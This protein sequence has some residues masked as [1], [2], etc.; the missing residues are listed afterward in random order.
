[1]ELAVLVLLTSRLM[2]DEIHRQLAERGYASLRPAHGF[3]FQLIASRGG[4]TGVELA[5]HLSVTRQAAGQMVDEL[6]RS[7]Y[8]TRQP[9]PTDARLRRVHLS[10]RGREVLELSARLWAAQERDWERL[11][12]E[13][14]IA[15]VQSGLAAFIQDRGGFD[16]PLR[17]R[18]TW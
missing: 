10:D 17:L 18:P 5:D 4:A 8:V 14:G 6:E 16:P 2:T 12:G 1:M 13:Q 7:G 15:A 11:I 9:D 3:A